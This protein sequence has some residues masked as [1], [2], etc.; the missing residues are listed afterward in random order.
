ME[1]LSLVAA[2]PNTP[3]F[4]SLAARYQALTG[5]PMTVYTGNYYD[6][7]MVLAKAYFTTGSTDAGV[8]AEV[9]PSICASH[10]GVTGLCTLDEFGDRVPGSF[11]I[12]TYH[13]AANPADPANAVV[14]GSIDPWNHIVSWDTGEL[15]Y[16]PLGP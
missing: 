13:T 11:Q 3:E 8:I 2:T 10:V 4:N 1:F 5:L 14:V 9:I 16:T 7:G 12:W 6:I 15:G